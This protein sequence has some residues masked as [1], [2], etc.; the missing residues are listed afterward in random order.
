MALL[1]PYHCSSP[2]S[3]RC[4]G[5]AALPLFV[6]PAPSVRGFVSGLRRLGPSR[7]PLTPP[8]RRSARL[9]YR[10]ALTTPSTSTSPAAPL[11]WS[12]L[13]HSPPHR[14]CPSSLSTSAS[15]TSLSP[16]GSASV[17]SGTGVPTLLPTV[18]LWPC[19]GPRGACFGPLRG[20]CAAL[21]RV[22]MS[23]TSSFE[24]V[25]AGAAPCFLH[26][27]CLGI[28]LRLSLPLCLPRLSFHWIHLSSPVL[29]PGGGGVHWGSWAFLCLPRFPLA[30]SDG[31]CRLR[32]SAG[33][34][35][36]GVSGWGFSLGVPGLLKSYVTALVSEGLVLLSRGP[37]GLAWLTPV[38]LSSWRTGVQFP[39]CQCLVGLPA[40]MVLVCAG[41][42]PYLYPVLP[43]LLLRSLF[44]WS[45]FYLFRVCLLRTPLSAL[46]RCR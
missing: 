33:G 18:H 42:L 5:L 8:V 32:D 23:I 46:Y 34:G 19:R 12:D 39:L 21:R 14:R 10:T 29:V 45:G 22:S 35:P 4:E 44:I 1:L 31:A 20:F 28:F 40:L 15:S 26:R 2:L 16:S 43:P 3:L 17:F 6:S 38:A 30:W 36:L 41:F 11:V 9:P 27:F 13:L 7:A 25:G 37:A 24:T